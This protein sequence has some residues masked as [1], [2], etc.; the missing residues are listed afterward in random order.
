MKITIIGA[1]NMGRGIGTRAIAGGHEVEILDRDPAEARALADQLGGS[2][3]VLDP[4]G[5]FGGEVVVFASTTPAS[6]KPSSSTPIFSACRQGR[7]R[8][9]ESDRHRDGGQAGHAAR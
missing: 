7:R 6:R 4:S 3:S 2:A 1:G 8:H 5:R 9:H